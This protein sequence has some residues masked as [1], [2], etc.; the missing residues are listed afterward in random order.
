MRPVPPQRLGRI[1]M[2]AAAGILTFGA[3]GCEDTTH[4]PVTYR[5]PQNVHSTAPSVARMESFPLDPANRAK[6]RPLR[7]TPAENIDKL[8]E[9]VEAAFATGE[10]EY[11]AG[12]TESARQHFDH[13]L[14]LLL[15]SGFDLDADPR[16]SS[17]FH[18]IV[19]T[20]HNDALLALQ[21]GDA[22][23]EQRSEPAPI[24]EIAA[25][26]VPGAPV[27]PG[28]R[29]SAEGEI[30]AVAHD[31]PLTVND[32]VLSYLNYFQTPR[33]RAIVETG[34]RRAGR[35]RPMIQRVLHE[36]GLPNDIMYLAQAESAFQP[37]AL[38]RAGARGLWQFMSYRG[39]EYGLE[40][41][42]WV[43]DRQ[44]PEKA[45]QAAARHLRDLYQMFGDWYLAMAAYNSGPGAVQHAIERTGYADFWDLYRLSAL[46]KETRN[47][48]PIILALTLIA[49]DPARYGVDVA[50][51]E[52][53]RA[54]SVQPG[55]SIDLRLVSEAIDSDLETLRMLNPQLLRQ[56]TPAD[57]DFVL[58]LPAGTA[59][60]F[61]AEIAAIPPDKW[62]NWRRHRVTQGETLSMIAQQ[63][64]VTTTA[65]AEANGLDGAAPLET[66]SKLTIPVAP[67]TQAS[68]GK[69]VSYRARRN[70]TLASIA[71]EFDV[72]VAE[73]KKWNHLRSDKLVRNARLKI[74]SGGTGGSAPAGTRSSKDS[75][76]RPSSVEAPVSRRGASEVALKSSSGGAAVTKQVAST[77]TTQSERP[78]LE[79]DTPRV[80]VHRVQ[81]GETLYSIAH[82]YQTTVEAL[83]KGNKFLFSRSLEAGDTL[84][85]FPPR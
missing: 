31:L 45:T 79:R 5:P 58:H 42:W 17:L 8:K 37:Q 47:Y 67:Q 6:V 12:H 78:L 23:G 26:G 41:S 57:P 54:D 60:E 83:R 62:T 74:Y 44:D 59:E 70:D 10:Q 30:A 66:G 19:D 2:L 77:N 75:P 50:P 65:L 4:R 33:G 76:N 81:S 43:D 55:H 18:Q 1:G 40:H 9:Q 22:A 21:D 72:S 36:E 82:A 64:R 73:L 38:S 68:L 56:V 39:K 24:D 80:I 32:I 35:Y 46:P 63:Y 25:E 27:D 11:K 14:D 51:E 48:V 34:L 28:L 13:A 69:L 15:E 29:T 7:T 16:L 20:A 3:I 61:R 49:K 52:P 85:I 53:L 71:N 84:T